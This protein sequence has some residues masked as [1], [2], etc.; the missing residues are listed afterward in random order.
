MKAMDL[1]KMALQS[2]DQF[3]TQLIDDMRDAPLTQPTS[4]GGNH[5]LW[6]LGHLAIGEGLIRQVVLGESNPVA[7]WEGIFGFGSEPS[8][9]AS[10]YPSFDEVMEKYRELRA[11]NMR[12]LDE[13][14]E[15]GLDRPTKAPPPGLE[16]LF[17]TAGQTFLITA[18][19][20]MNHRGQVADARRMAGRKPVFTPEGAAA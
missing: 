7:H 8:D 4:N 14:G 18:M 15:E 13:L 20:Q 10:D 11:E 19:H 5:P 9:N 16:A 17:Q 2:S 6:V 1:I 3:T 12:L